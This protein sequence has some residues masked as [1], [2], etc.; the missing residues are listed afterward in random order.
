MCVPQQNLLH[1]NAACA[2][3]FGQQGVAVGNMILLYSL[4]VTVWLTQFGTGISGSRKL[5]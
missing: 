4:E 2:Y 5:L 1:Y 3:A